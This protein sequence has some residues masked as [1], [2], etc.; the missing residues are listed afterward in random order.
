MD[1]V[2]IQFSYFCT[3]DYIMVHCDQKLLLIAQVIE[4]DYE[5]IF[6]N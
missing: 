6:N 3:G 2:D 4:S 1:C 5:Y